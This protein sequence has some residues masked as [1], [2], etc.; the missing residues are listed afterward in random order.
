MRKRTYLILLAS[1]CLVVIAAEAYLLTKYFSGKNPSKAQPATSKEGQEDEPLQKAYPVRR[2]VKYSDEGLSWDDHDISY[3]YGEDGRVLRVITTTKY[4]PFSSDAASVS[5]DTISFRYDRLGN[6]MEVTVRSGDDSE[7]KALPYS[8]EGELFEFVTDYYG[9]VTFL[10][11]PFMPFSYPVSPLQNFSDIKKNSQGRIISYNDTEC[12]HLCEYDERGNMVR[13]IDI[14]QSSGRELRHCDFGYDEH[15]RIRSAKSNYSPC[16]NIAQE[17]FVYDA[18]GNAILIRY[19]SI[20]GSWVFDINREY[21]EDNHLI[22]ETITQDDKD[23]PRIRRE[24]RLFHVEERYLTDVERRDLGL[25][26]NPDRI[27]ASETLLDP[28]TWQISSHHLILY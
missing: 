1:V 23:T 26:Y 11:S 18:Q 7:E 6:L 25:P 19:Y 17:E 12:R 22:R 10:G 27:P 9:G 3:E 14:E 21:D 20:D 28:Y 5:T 2:M 13:R 4:D 8:S 15:D 16:D 24:Y